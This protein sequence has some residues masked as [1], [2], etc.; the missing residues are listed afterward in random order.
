MKIY[1]AKPFSK[2]KYQLG[3][4][5][6]YDSRTKT[7]SWVD[8]T[9]GK[10][11]TLSGDGKKTEYAIGQEIGAALPTEKKDTY[12]IAGTDGLYLLDTTTESPSPKLIKD[13]RPYFESFQRSNDAKADP[14]GRL[15]LGSSVKDNHEPCGNLFCLDPFNQGEI[16]CRQPDTKI[17]NGMAWSRDH[18]RF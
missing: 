8:I 7:L 11:Y 10:F 16:T 17:S 18:K 12:L 5:P 6:F 13:L 4:G 2:E 15:W 3:E 1:T 14:K 9:E